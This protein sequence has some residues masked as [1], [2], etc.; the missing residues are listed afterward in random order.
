MPGRETC[1]HDDVQPTASEAY[2]T[3]KDYCSRVTSSLEKA[4]VESERS[5]LA[6]LEKIARDV[7]AEY[8]QRRNVTE[9][10]FEVKDGFGKH[11]T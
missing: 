2:Y 10:S 11:L 1:M 9:A 6:K 8:T 7:N 3:V 4:L 5:Q